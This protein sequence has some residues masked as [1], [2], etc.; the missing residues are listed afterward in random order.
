VFIP[1]R[2]NIF[3]LIFQLF[4]TSKQKS[5][6][7]LL[8]YLTRIQLFKKFPLVALAQGLSSP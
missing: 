6:S 2:S 1:G 3:L 7:I 4:I 8:R 5:S